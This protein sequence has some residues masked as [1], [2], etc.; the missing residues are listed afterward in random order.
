[1]PG[2]R[3]R[4]TPAIRRRAVSP[5]YDGATLT[6]YVDG[7]QSGATPNQTGNI[8]DTTSRFSVGAQIFGGSVWNRF[9]GGLVDECRVYDVALTPDQIVALASGQSDIDDEPGLTKVLTSGDL[10]NAIDPL[11]D[12]EDTVEE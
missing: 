4:P 12:P 2:D 10:A 9:F 1:V 3:R 8:P 6:V 5:V 11:C 7:A